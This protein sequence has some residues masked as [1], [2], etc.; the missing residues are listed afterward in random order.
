MCIK[1]KDGLI[2]KEFLETL[3]PKDYPRPSVTAD[4]LIFS[5]TAKGIQILLIK[6]GNHPDVGHWA[7]P[8]G[9][10]N[11]DETVSQTASRELYEETHIKNLYLEPLGLFSDPDRD[12]RE[13]TITNAYMALTDKSKLSVLADDDAEDI[14]WFNLTLTA[15]DN[16]MKLTA[17]ADDINLTAELEYTIKDTIFGKR[18]EINIIK[19]G[20]I[21]FDHAKIIT[22][23]IL[24]LKEH[25]L[26]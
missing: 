12:A 11:P 21:A 8:G 23:G 24:K 20:G 25:K 3:N 18:Y 10:S 4:I 7:L 13:W 26:I 22:Y 6:R 9:F 2:E 19:N 16:R 14:K 17:L 15:C 1:N 5:K